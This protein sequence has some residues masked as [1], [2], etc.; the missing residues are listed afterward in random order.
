MKT[1]RML[2]MG[3]VDLKIK[4]FFVNPIELSEL[5]DKETHRSDLVGKMS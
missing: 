1:N 2:M 5:S 3:K 4:P